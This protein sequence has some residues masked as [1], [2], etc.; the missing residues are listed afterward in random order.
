MNLLLTI[1]RNRRYDNSTYSKSDDSD[2]ECVTGDRRVKQA[3]RHNEVLISGGKR[4]PRHEKLAVIKSSDPAF[5]RLMNYWY[6]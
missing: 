2:N 3:E 1:M 6:Y 5:N 4:R